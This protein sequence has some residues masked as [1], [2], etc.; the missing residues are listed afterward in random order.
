M[1]NNFNYLYQFLNWYAID[2]KKFD[3]KSTLNESAQKAMLLGIALRENV[4]NKELYEKLE[5]PSWKFKVF[6]ILNQT[7]LSQLFYR[8]IQLKSAFNQRLL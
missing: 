6:Y 4:R 2:L 3:L 8:L 7:F 5:Q 1:Q